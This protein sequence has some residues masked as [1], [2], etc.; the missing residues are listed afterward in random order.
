V[1]ELLPAIDLRAGQAVRLLQGDFAAETVYSSDPVEVAKSYEAGGAKW[2]HVVDLDAARTGEPANL[3]LVEAIASA[4]GC[5][6]EVGG[7]VRTPE[8]AARLFDAGADRVVVGTAAVE[9]P[10][11][12]AEL[13]RRHPG[14]VAAGLDARGRQLAVRGWT[15]TTGSDV[16][17]AA[18]RLEASGVAALVVTEIGRDGT[19]AGADL[20]QLAAVLEATTGD[21]IASGGV[22]SLEDLRALAALRTA[23]RSLAGVIVGRAL[24]EGRFTVE[25]AVEALACSPPG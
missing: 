5:A 1:S 3:S 9:E 18:R 23:G 16:I 10:G 6:L 11:L 22:G 15:Q 19:M 20:D 14:R 2:I 17:E 13:C 25:E 21:V 7:G 8:A 24:L 4:V 12:V